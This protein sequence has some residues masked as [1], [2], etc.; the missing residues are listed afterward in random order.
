MKEPMFVRQG[1]AFAR[2]ESDRETE[3]DANRHDSIMAFVAAWE[4]FHIPAGTDEMI[5]DRQMAQLIGRW[6]ELEFQQAYLDRLA[7]F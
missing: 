6:G 2:P 5:M 3:E 1:R 7:N 4:A